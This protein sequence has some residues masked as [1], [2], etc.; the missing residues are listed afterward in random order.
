MVY[1]RTIRS[2]MWPLA[3]SVAASQWLRAVVSGTGPCK[4]PPRSTILTRK[5]CRLQF[6]H[7]YCT[8][9]LLSLKHEKTHICAVFFLHL[10][11][12]SALVQT[13]VLLSVISNMQSGAAGC[14]GDCCTCMGNRASIDRTIQ[15]ISL[16]IS[17][18]SSEW[19]HR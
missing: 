5:A 17:G 19:A 7:W 14:R 3:A 12:C 16:S 6:Q 13:A 10:P 11:S 1:C 9:S 18:N 4:A 8:P 15:E 2:G